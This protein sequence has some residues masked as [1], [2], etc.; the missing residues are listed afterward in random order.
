MVQVWIWGVANGKESGRSVSLQVAKGMYCRLPRLSVICVRWEVSG[1]T[2]WVEGLSL[3]AENALVEGGVLDVPAG[4][5][6]VSGVTRSNC[7]R[8][9]SI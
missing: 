7:E 8:L 4:S 6:M 3:W 2:R 5:Y 1:R 9:C